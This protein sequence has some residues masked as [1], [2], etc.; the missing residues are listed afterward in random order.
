[1][2]TSPNSIAYGYKLTASKILLVMASGNVESKIPLAYRA[3]HEQLSKLEVY[4]N[5]VYIVP[6]KFGVA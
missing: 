6:R 1:M 2:K 4:K 5:N 3:L